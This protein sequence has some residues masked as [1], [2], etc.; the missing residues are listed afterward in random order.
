MEI[1]C[2]TIG[3]LKERY[4]L[5][6]NMTLMEKKTLQNIFHREVLSWAGR[7]R[8]RD[9]IKKAEELGI[10]RRYRDRK[11]FLKMIGMFLLRDRVSP[12]IKKETMRYILLDYEIGQLRQFYQQPSSSV[13]FKNR[14]RRM[15]RSIASN[16][17][18]I[19]LR[20]S[21]FR[22]GIPFG[23]REKEIMVD[24]LGLLWFSVEIVHP[25]Y[26]IISSPH[27]EED[28]PICTDSLTENSEKVKLGCACPSIYHKECI[29]KWATISFS[30]PTCRQD[31]LQSSSSSKK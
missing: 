29:D 31:L 17:F 5:V 26:T 16:I 30:C 21:L 7:I 25:N 27:H 3:C 19:D 13:S 1:F 10:L 23:F 4:G 15:I 8:V 11:D 6:E 9:C 20:N 2:Q 28:C 24:L 22:L 18:M 12:Q 14:S